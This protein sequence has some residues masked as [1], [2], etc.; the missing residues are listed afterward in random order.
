MNYTDYIEQQKQRETERKALSFEPDVFQRRALKT[1]YETGDALHFDPLPARIGVSGEGGEIG[2]KIKKH[3]YKPDYDW[4]VDDEVEELGDIFYY[5]C[6]R[7]YQLGVTVEEMSCR[8]REKLSDGNNGWP[9][10]EHRF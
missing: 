3:M 7:L 9:E 2:N 10:V 5:I 1:W 6:I 8:N 4:T